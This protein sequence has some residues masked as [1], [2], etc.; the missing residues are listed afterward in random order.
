M[1]GKE[2]GE[3][4]KGWREEEKKVGRNRNTIVISSK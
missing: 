3:A 4:R 1:G 2:E